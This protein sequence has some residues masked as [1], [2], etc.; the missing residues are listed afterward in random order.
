[1]PE[2]SCSALAKL[3]ANWASVSSDSV[4]SPSRASLACHGVCWSKNKGNQTTWDSMAKS[5][6]LNIPDPGIFSVATIS[7]RQPLS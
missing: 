2:A 7:A 3:A 5:T 1:V 4:L 6:K